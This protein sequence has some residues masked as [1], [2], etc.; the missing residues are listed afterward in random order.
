MEQALRAAPIE[1]VRDNPYL[2]EALNTFSLPYWNWFESPI[3]P[4]IF[5]KETLMVEY[6][7]SF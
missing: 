5:T 3:V 6:K 1:V 7:T 4:E 2:N